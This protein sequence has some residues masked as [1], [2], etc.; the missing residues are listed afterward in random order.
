VVSRDGIINTIAG[1]GAPAVWC[2]ET[3]ELVRMAFDRQIDR[4][5]GDPWEEVIRT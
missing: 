3:T 2:L 5:E 4:Y 1:T